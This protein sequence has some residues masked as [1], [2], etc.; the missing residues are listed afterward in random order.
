MPLLT[1]SVCHELQPNFSLKMMAKKYTWSGAVASSSSSATKE[2]YTL[3]CLHGV[4]F[5][6]ELWEPVLETLFSESHAR[7]SPFVIEEAWA[8]DM[9][10]HGESGTANAA[11]LRSPQYAEV[12]HSLD[13]ATATYDFV[14]S[15]I[16]VNDRTGMPA[17][18]LIGVGHSIGG[19]TLLNVAKNYS[20]LFT[21]LCLFDPMGFPGE[22]HRTLDAIIQA[23][24][25]HAYTRRDIWPNK[26]AAFKD[27]SKNRLF[28][29][30]DERSRRIFVEH[31]LVEHEASNYSFPYKGVTLRC[32]R[33][34][35]AAT[36]RGGPALTRSTIPHLLEINNQIP[37]YASFGQNPDTLPGFV[38]ETLLKPQHSNFIQ[39]TRI[40]DA[41]HL[42]IFEKPTESGIMLHGF[43]EHLT[44]NVV[45][46]SSNGSS[47]YV[48][49]P[50]DNANQAGSARSGHAQ[51]R[52]G[53]RVLQ[54]ASRL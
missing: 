6:K 44:L 49:E 27:L 4:G 51:K 24:C 33:D 32:T 1:E 50:V 17:V 46:P 39:V 45:L 30:W 42:L 36:C 9:P 10:N 22:H 29:S 37:S 41:G 5:C 52:E 47:A 43:I 53:G 3:L 8:I 38:Q 23:F 40:P 48:G 13:W 54:M 12:F 7:N 14:K 19:I 18:K 25:E 28:K 31:G 20:N 2:R 21:S 35:E 34:Q 15:K 26:Q 11:V 16:G